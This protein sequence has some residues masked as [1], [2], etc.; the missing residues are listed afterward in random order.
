MSEIQSIS[1]LSLS[2]AKCARIFFLGL[3]IFM[4]IPSYP[5]TSNTTTVNQLAEIEILFEQEINS[6]DIMDG[7][8]GPLGIAVTSNRIFVTM[9][10]LNSS[11]LILD[12]S[13]NL[14]RIISEVNGDK[15]QPHG[16]EASGNYLFVT[17]TL[18]NK[19]H[20]FDI[21]G[22]Y[23]D[24]FGR[25][26]T[27]SGRFD[28]PLDIAMN[29]EFLY[30]ADYGNDRVQ[31]FYHDGEYYGEGD[32]FVSQVSYVAA[33]EANFYSTSVR[34]EPVT[35]YSKLGRKQGEWGDAKFQYRSNAIRTGQGEFN[36]GAPNGI[37]VAGPYVFIGD[38][39]AGRIQAFD[40]LGHYLTDYLSIDND[41]FQFGRLQDLAANST[42]IFA[43]DTVHRSIVLFT[44]QTVQASNNVIV[45]NNSTYTV[46]P[47]PTYRFYN[48]PRNRETPI[49]TQWMVVGIFFVY[50]AKSRTAKRKT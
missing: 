4:L 14:L 43:L 13:F 8:F 44:H 34:T 22:N 32:I 26:G 45:V 21:G 39:Q 33:N 20:G 27:Q 25:E 47:E 10:S 50:L 17:D 42:H 3:L 11:I 48:T 29:E 37:T 28:Q 38:W 12:H 46:I 23:S 2:R 16:I 31:I 24:S 30:V 7:G 9:I 18:N 19:V 5:T 40:Q 41:I 36:T 35:K 1:V 6:T 49:S 15:F